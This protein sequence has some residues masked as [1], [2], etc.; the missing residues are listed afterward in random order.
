MCT[1]VPLHAAC[2]RRHSRLGRN[3]RMRL[4][5]RTE[6]GAAGR[7]AGAGLSLHWLM[8]CVLQGG[9]ASAIGSLV[10]LGRGGLMLD[11]GALQR[12]ASCAWVFQQS[13]ARVHHP[14]TRRHAHTASPPLS[15]NQHHP[16]PCTDRCPAKAS[17][18]DHRPSAM[19]QNCGGTQL[20]TP[21]SIPLKWPSGRRLTGAGGSCSG[22]ERSLLTPWS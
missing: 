19:F 3:G 17:G 6:V 2:S 8:L 11:G 4:F 21:C 1:A 16:Q 12:S 7:C 22:P 9:V 18:E 15:W 10:S 5:V 14:T 13:R 20:S